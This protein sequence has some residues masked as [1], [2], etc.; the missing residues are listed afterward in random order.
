MLHVV[1][2][3]TQ[4]HVL[5][6][7]RGET[8]PSRKRGKLAVAHTSR[9]SERVVTQER[10]EHSTLCRIRHESPHLVDHPRKFRADARF[11]R[12]RCRE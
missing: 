1:R 12:V 3:R 9:L 7:D 10:E 2:G 6:Q 11:V 4:D 5:A 8:E